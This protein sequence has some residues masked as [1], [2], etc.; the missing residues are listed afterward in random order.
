MSREGKESVQ[1]CFGQN[2]CRGID[3]GM[4]EKI[5]SLPD[6]GVDPE[7]DLMPGVVCQSHHGH[8]AARHAQNAL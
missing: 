6:L 4:T 5:F 2:Q 3:K 1:I 8:G 7:L